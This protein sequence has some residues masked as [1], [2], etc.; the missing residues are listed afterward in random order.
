MFDL[1]KT[2]I[3]KTITKKQNP[4]LKQN[5]SGSELQVATC[6]LLLEIAHADDKLT[7]DEEQ[8]I[9]ELMESHFS[10][11]PESFAQLKG[12][13]EKKRKTNIDLW[14]FT[15]TIKENYSRQQ[16]LKVVEMIW[17]VIYADNELD[18]YEDYLVH[19]LA[20]LLGISHRELIDAKLKVKKQQATCTQHI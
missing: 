5:Y 18:E 6:A 12:E 4:D 20:E 11:S 9:A 3:K 13:S 17:G 19:K 14:H 7:T 1:I 8:K 16:K 2:A 10:L 15:S